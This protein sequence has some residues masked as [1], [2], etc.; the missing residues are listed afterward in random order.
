MAE[1]LGVLCF[2]TVAAGG[3][4]AASGVLNVAS[5]STGS[6]ILPFPGSGTFSVCISD[7]T[8]KAPKALL[9]VTGINSG[10][11]FAV[12]NSGGVDVN[13]LAGDIVQAVIDARALT[14]ILAGSWTALAPLYQN[15]YADFGSG[16]QAG[17]YSKDGTGRVWT[18]G[19]GKT[20]AVP[21]SGD[22]VYTLPSG[23]RPPAK[24]TVSSMELSGSNLLPAQFDIDTTGDVTVFFDG[25]PVA[26][27][28]L[29]LSISFS[30]N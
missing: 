2:T 4:T 21:N 29:W 24:Q 13:C 30:V 25:A 17:Q 8:T 19:L 6:G 16:Y 11:Q 18:R 22:L 28:A 5:T 3:Y 10:T 26:N 20:P 15:G 23:F 12:T 7:P 27:T 1:Q 9:E 14:A